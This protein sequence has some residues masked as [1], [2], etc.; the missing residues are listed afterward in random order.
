MHAVRHSRMPAR[1]RVTLLFMVALAACSTGRDSGPRTPPPP[2]QIEEVVPQAVTRSRTVNPKSYVVLGQRYFVLDSADGYRERGVASWYGSKFHGRNTSSGEVYDM[3][4]ASAAHRSLPLP[5]YARVTNL[6]NGRSLIVRV[7][8]RGP[9]VDNRLIDLSYG[10]AN[11]LGMIDAGTALVEV[12]VVTP[13][14]W[15]AVPA[16][17]VV[18]ETRN[19]PG[20]LYVQVGA[21][22]E[23]ANANRQR[24]F[25]L[26]SG[27]DDVVIRQDSLNGKPLYRVRIGP[28]DSVNDFDRMVAQARDL[29]ISDAHLATE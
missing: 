19:V 10:A 26:Q 1:L 11:E 16:N 15:Q 22:A 25:L 6:E 23:R 7:N 4:Q 18:V 3:Y 28:I 24:A 20:S 2:G 14:N 9:F 8:D 29:G 13:D 27:I 21:Y 5:S 17:E 12:Q